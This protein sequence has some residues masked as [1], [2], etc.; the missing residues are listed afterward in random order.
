[1]RVPWVIHMCNIR[2]GWRVSFR[3][4]TTHYRALLRKMAY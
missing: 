2:T 1:M 3:Q 4:R